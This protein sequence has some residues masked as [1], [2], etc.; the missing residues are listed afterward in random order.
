MFPGRISIG[1]SLLMGKA[2]QRR[3]L[4]AAERSGEYIPVS[5]TKYI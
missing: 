3:V 4:A 2:S 1:E 5:L